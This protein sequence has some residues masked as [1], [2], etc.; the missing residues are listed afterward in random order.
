MSKN[1]LGSAASLR[2]F[3]AQLLKFCTPRFNPPPS[4]T[5][6]SQIIRIGLFFQPVAFRIGI[7]AADAQV[8][9]ADGVNAIEG[10]HAFF[11][12]QIVGVT[13]NIRRGRAVGSGHVAQHVFQNVFDIDFKFIGQLCVNIGRIAAAG[14]AFSDNRIEVDLK[15]I[16]KKGIDGGH[17]FELVVP[18]KNQ[19]VNGER[20]FF[21]FLSK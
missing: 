4:L 15:F 14:F 8:F 6:T 21:L 13:K 3:L 9:C 5:P 1:C 17:F 16:Y 18:F 19:G 20:K 10:N 11:F 12:L 7:T 2:F